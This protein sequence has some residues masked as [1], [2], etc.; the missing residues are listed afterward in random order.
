MKKMNEGRDV[1]DIMLSDLRREDK[2]EES[3]KLA[4]FVQQ[5]MISG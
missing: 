2:R 4:T 1:L 3:L 5:N